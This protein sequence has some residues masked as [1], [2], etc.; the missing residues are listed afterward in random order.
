[1]YEKSQAT[2]AHIFA[3]AQR[4]FVANTYDDITMAAIASEA[5]VTKGAIYHHFKGKEELF[6]RMMVRYLDCL[7]ILLQQSVTKKGSARERLTLLTVLYLT[8][9]LEEQH[10]IQLVRRDA[11][12]FKDETRQRLVTAYQNAL[13][14]QI[15]TIIRE[16]VIAGE[17]IAGDTRLLA[18]QFVAIVEVYLSDYARQQ[19]A[20][21]NSMAAHLTDLFFD[22]VGSVSQ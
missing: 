6:L 22:G 20:D 13:P 19:F 18:W 4:L 15:E 21:P 14:N 16:G 8:Q 7:Q 2:I 11:N 5:Q 1:M 12:R 17:M 10:V 3:A 9:S